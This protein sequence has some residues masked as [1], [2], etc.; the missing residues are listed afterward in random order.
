VLVTVGRAPCTDGLG[1]EEAGVA[2]D[3]RGWA[4]EGVCAASG[5]DFIEPGIA[6]NVYQLVSAALYFASSSLL[7]PYGL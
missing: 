7:R 5:M 3:A 2:V 6:L 4:A 1:L